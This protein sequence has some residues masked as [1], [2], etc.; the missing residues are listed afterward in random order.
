MNQRYRNEDDFG[1]RAQVDENEH[2]FGQPSADPRFERDRNQRNRN[3]Y[4]RDENQFSDRN[5][6]SNGWNNYG[7]GDD[8]SSRNFGPSNAD[9]AYNY[10]SGDYR[11]GG[12]G[13]GWDESRSSGQRSSGQWGDRDSAPGSS[14]RN[15]QE[16]GSRFPRSQFSNEY[17]DYGSNRDYSR[18]NAGISRDNPF[19]IGGRSLI[20]GNVGQGAYLSFGDN[21]RQAAGFYS[22]SQ[23]RRGEHFGKGPKGY[24]RSDERI[25]EDVCDRLAEDDALDAR[26]ITVTIAKGEVTLDGS[27]PDRFSK[28]RAEDIVDSIS[29]VS[30]INN[31]LK[32]D[33][34]FFEDIGDRMMS[35]QEHSGHAGERPIESKNGHS[36]LS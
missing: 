18:P 33:K 28:H 15:N 2:Y 21:S 29:G 6:N 10:G 11:S 7:S 4:Q 32:V 17:R 8:S 13:R 23:Q 19:G 9:E 1:R 35:N 20:D 30:D 22:G 31:R 12:S 24:Q 16:Q 14:F 5:Q 26:N 34:G 3:R 25:R 27:V 36:S